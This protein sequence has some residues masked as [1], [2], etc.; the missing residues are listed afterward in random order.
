MKQFVV[1]HWSLFWVVFVQAIQIFGHD[2][3]FAWSGDIF[4][5]YVWNPTVD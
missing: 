3:A 1:R 4:Y 5:T 2:S